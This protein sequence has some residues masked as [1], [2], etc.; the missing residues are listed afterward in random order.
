MRQTK[1]RPRWTSFY[2]LAHAYARG[3]CDP[4][5]VARFEAAF[6]EWLEQTSYEAACWGALGE[7]GER[8]NANHL[9]TLLSCCPVRRATTTIQRRVSTLPAVPEFEID[10]ANAVLGEIV[11]DIIMMYTKR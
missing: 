5:K 11:P 3:T 10:L 8:D 2:G 4:D 9:K 6:K 7:I 1:N